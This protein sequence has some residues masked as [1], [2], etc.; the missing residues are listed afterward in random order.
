MAFFKLCQVDNFAKTLLYCEVPSYYTFNK[1]DGR[2]VRRKRGKCVTG[3]IGVFRDPAIGRV[4]TIHPQNSE[5][6]HLRLLLYN[7]RGPTSFEDIKTVLGKIHPTFKAAC[8][9]LGLLEDD[10]HWEDALREAALCNSSK[11][12][13]EL[14]AIMVVFCDLSDPT[15]LWLKFRDSLA[16]DYFRDAQRSI[17]STTFENAPHLYGLCLA[18]IE[19]VTMRIGHKTLNDCHLP[20][21]SVTCQQGNADFIRETSTSYNVS[22][23]L[24]FV[25][26][27]EPKL[28][29]E[30][31]AVYE[32]V[33]FSINSDS[34]QMFFLD[35]PGGT[36]KTFLIKLIL[37]K[38]RSQGKIAIAVASSGIAATLLPGGRTAHSMFKIP[39]NIE[40]METP[41]CSVSRNS[42][43]AEVLKECAL[44]VWDE[45]T[46]AHKKSIEALDRTLK[47]IRCNTSDM[48]GLTILFSGDFRQTLPVITRGTRADEINAC[49]KKSFIWTK[50]SRVSLSTNMRVQLQ[51]EQE[52]QQFSDL[53]LK[54]GQGD[55][56]DNNGFIDVPSSLCTTVT[57][58]EEL[59]N[60]VFPPTNE[61]A[62][63][64]NK[65][66]LSSFEAEERKYLSINT[67]MNGDN[68]IHCPV[69]LLESVI[70]PG[71]PA[72]ELII[73]IGAPIMLLRN[74]NPPK[75][76]NGTRLRVKALHRFV[77]ET[78]ILTGCAAGESV[79]IPRIPLIPSNYPFE[80][81]R[82]QFPISI[83]FAMTVNKSQ[84]QT[85]STA[86][87]DVS[88]VECF[89]HGQFYVAC[90]RVSYLHIF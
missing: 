83:C 25:S 34:S 55:V 28:S 62:A 74:I 65:K 32:S 79:F 53:L 81:K 84:G 2:F 49:I 6:F 10:V 16:E 9:V 36:E 68:F 66:I 58:Q 21:P 44:I 26:E 86:G 15:D 39:I 71:L 64:I 27:N 78:D 41:V 54:I 24:S 33:L 52:A 87:I 69:E 82:L 11:K 5:C 89:S 40:Q 70:A 18:N 19:E 14:F 67:P 80:F 12:L 72:H 63:L 8:K 13:R 31:I 20:S 60:N 59:I 43:V 29:N 56:E 1:S 3:H 35:A 73:K 51:G 17:L 57:S 7:V 77:I 85:L 38:V 45:C 37:A 75:L 42:P 46:M 48:G 90:S 30:Q 47:D 50:I 22:E 4:Y 88:T 61:Q 23:L 76:C